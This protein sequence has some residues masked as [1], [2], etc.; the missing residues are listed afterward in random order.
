M[1]YDSYHQNKKNAT[2]PNYKTQININHLKENLQKEYK[3]YDTKKINVHKRDNN[4]IHSVNNNKF[5][6]YKLNTFQNINN[7]KLYNTNN[8][9]EN[10]IKVNYS[11]YTSRKNSN[12]SY[13][14][15]N[16]TAKTSLKGG[17]TTVIQHYSGKRARFDDYSKDSIKK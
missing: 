6:F 16:A 3:P 13:S 5:N 2:I 15:S 9:N 8:D 7:K 1:K 12:A 4:N 10:D 17:V 11:N 14:L